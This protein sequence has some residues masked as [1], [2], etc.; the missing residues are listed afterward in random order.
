MKFLDNI[1]KNQ[2][3][4]RFIETTQSHMVTAEIGNSS[5]VV[6]YYLLLSLFPLLIA[7]GNVLPYLRIDPNSVL[8]YIAEAIPK[9][10]YKNL[11]PA[12]RS[13]LTQ[14]SGGLLSVSALAAF[15]SA[16][17][18]KN[19]I[20]VRVVSF[21]VILLFMVAIVGVVVILGLGQYIIELLQPIFHYST[22]VIDTFQALKWPL[23]TVVLLVIMCLIY[24]VVPNRK[25][26]LRS[27]L[28]GAIF[29]TV[30][31]MLLS[32]IFGLY[33]KY[34]SSRIASYQIIGSFIIL[35]LWLNFAATIIILGAIVNAVVDEYLSGDKEKKQP[36]FE[37]RLF[38]WF[39][40]KNK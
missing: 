10:V 13:L 18:R 37:Q 8:P 40:K 9:D 23:T 26:S 22:S 31:W 35:M 5:V 19:F 32:Q 28:P 33:V 12:I 16:S 3:L 7:V 25:L 39:K 15:W 11:E 4:M 14:R 24:A 27:I 30:G 21:L 36:S 34:F 2:S 38:R 1:K 6:A 17:Q 20:L 29:S